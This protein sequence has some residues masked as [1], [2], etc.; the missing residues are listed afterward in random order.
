MLRLLVYS[1]RNIP[2]TLKIP[3]SEN[4]PM[5]DTWSLA[6]IVRKVEFK[7]LQVSGGTGVPPVRRHRSFRV[8]R[9]GPGQSI[10]DHDGCDQKRIESRFA[11]GSRR[12]PQSQQNETAGV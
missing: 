11:A 10:L 5:S 4:P 6:K 1:W 9:P 7:L 3:D 12:L 8:T 2:I